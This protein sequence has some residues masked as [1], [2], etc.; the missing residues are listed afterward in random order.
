MFL[1]TTVSFVLYATETF[2]PV[3]HSETYVIGIFLLLCNS[4][5]NPIVY[6]YRTPELKKISQH[7]LG[8]KGT[9]E[10]RC[11]R[12]TDMVEVIRETDVAVV[13]GSVTGE[14]VFSSAA[15]NLQT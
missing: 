9:A 7:L 10:L 4:A 2:S 15:W 1:P 5:V 11:R 13:R 3:A 8:L 14:Q 12:S 6:T